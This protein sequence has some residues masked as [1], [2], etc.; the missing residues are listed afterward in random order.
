MVAASRLALFTIFSFTVAA[1]LRS[2]AET[3][4]DLA[5]YITTVRV[6]Q[7]LIGL[8]W[9]LHDGDFSTGLVG[10]AIIVGAVL[11]TFSNQL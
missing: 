5:P 3:L 4:P 1:F 9:W 2:L 10:I 7:L 6:L 11:G 8:V